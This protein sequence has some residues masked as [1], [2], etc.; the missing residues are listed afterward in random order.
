M[1]ENANLVG[2]AVGELMNRLIQGGVD[3]STIHL[4]GYMIGAH[5]AG[6]AARTVNGTVEYL[7]GKY[8]APCE[9]DIGIDLENIYDI[10]NHDYVIFDQYFVLYTA[11]D[12]LNWGF[13]L[14]DNEDHLQAT[15]ANVVQVIHTNG[16]ILGVAKACGTADFFLNSGY[17]L[18]PGCWTP[19]ST[20]TGENFNC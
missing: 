2:T 4:V 17:A 3:L 11:L 10:H 5:V 14:N 1:V 7:V 6:K 13:Y 19:W 20:Y 8:A 18:Q 9:W 16:L 12:P 15:D